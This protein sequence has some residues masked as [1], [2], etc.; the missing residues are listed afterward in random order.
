MK[1]KSVEIYPVY[2]CDK[3]HSRHCESLDYVNRVSRIL[4]GCGKLMSLKKIKTFNISPVYEEQQKP[5]IIREIRDKQKPK[6]HSDIMQNIKNLEEMNVEE[7]SR[8]TNQKQEMPKELR[9]RA[10]SLL[11]SLGWKKGDAKESIDR[12]SKMWFS[13]K[14][15]PINSE[16]FNDFAEYL[17]RN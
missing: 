16:T 14:T 5:P 8:T 15:I 2:I 11:S 7:V 13:E 6:S 1:P 17:L 9:D 12:V 3:C 10:I 4:C